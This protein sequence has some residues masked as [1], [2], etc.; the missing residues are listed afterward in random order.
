METLLVAAAVLIVAGFVVH[1][2]RRQARA[3]LAEAQERIAALEA[4]I[5]ARRERCEALEANE[6]DMQAVTDT[7]SAA[8]ARCSADLRYLWVN[9]LYAEW[10]GAGRTPED[11]MGRPMA[12]VLGAEALEKMRPHI[13]EVLSGRR[14]EYERYAARP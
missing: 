14:V 1:W 8:V 12:D 5:E 9:R 13:R 11:M 2:A 4:A 6:R 7:M 10:A 3:R